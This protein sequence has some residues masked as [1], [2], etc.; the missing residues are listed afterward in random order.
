MIRLTVSS[1]DSLLIAWS[2]FLRWQTTK[3][4]E[5]Y[6]RRTMYLFVYKSRMVDLF[7]MVNL[8]VVNVCGGER[9]LIYTLPW[10]AN[11]FL[12]NARLNLSKFVSLLLFWMLP[13]NASSKCLSHAAKFTVS[14]AELYPTMIIISR[15]QSMIIVF[16]L[17][18]TVCSLS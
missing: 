12:I 18:Y 1:R 13:V 3:S 10:I 17:Y 11:R 7:H 14:L 16:W 5:N 4:P 9:V 6:N 15:I 8:F 2:C